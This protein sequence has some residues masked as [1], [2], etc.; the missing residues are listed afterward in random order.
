MWGVFHSQLPELFINYGSVLFFL[1]GIVV[2]FQTKERLKKY[3]SETMVLLAVTAF[4]LYEVNMIG[5]EHDYYLF[6]FIPLIFLIVA[7][8]IKTV[9]SSRKT[10][11][12]YLGTVALIILPLTAY[13]RVHHRWTPMGNEQALLLH[14]SE[15]R[16]LTPNDELIIV[17][18]DQS[19]HIYLYHLCKKGWTFEQNWLTSEQLKDRIDRGAKYLYS[20]TEFVEQESTIQ[21]FL[22]EPIFDKDGITVYPLKPTNGS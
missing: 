1:F 12:Q 5:M 16:K 15:L 13:L 11:L 10:W 21:Q 7:A 4:Y 8:G 2:F 19:T 3:A 6:P 14:K 20:N 22:G 17:G 9:L 18:N